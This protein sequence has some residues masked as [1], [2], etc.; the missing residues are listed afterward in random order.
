[1]SALVVAIIVLPA[2]VTIVTLASLWFAQASGIAAAG[3]CPEIVPIAGRLGTARCE[4]RA[5][6]EGPHHLPST[7]AH[8]EFWW[9]TDAAEKPKE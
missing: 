5:G 9:T 6:H 3:R 8:Y 4:F 2:S 1:M 7:S